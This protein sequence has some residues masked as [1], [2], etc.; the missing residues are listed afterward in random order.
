MSRFPLLIKGL[1]GTPALIL[2]LPVVLAAVQFARSFAQSNKCCIDGF[3]IAFY[4]TLRRLSIERAVGLG[5]RA[6]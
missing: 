3:Q 5:G 2:L 6:D 1:I 4:V